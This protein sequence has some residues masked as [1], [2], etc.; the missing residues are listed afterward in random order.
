MNL[1]SAKVV[2]KTKQ[3]TGRIHVC[4]VVL[5]T[6]WLTSTMVDLAPSEKC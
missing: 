1:F 4:G 6:E 2:Y 5:Q 3:K